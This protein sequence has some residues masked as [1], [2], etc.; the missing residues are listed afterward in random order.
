M[1]RFDYLGAVPNVRIGN[2]QGRCIRVRSSYSFVPFAGLELDPTE[3][4]AQLAASGEYAGV[5]VGVDGEKHFIKAL[6]PEMADWLGSLREPCRIDE[7]EGFT[8]SEGLRGLVGLVLDG[9]LEIESEDGFCSES[10]AYHVLIADDAEVAGST[11]A[12]DDISLRAIRHAS[13]FDT[14]EA[15]FLAA[16]LY[17]YGRRPVTRRWLN[18]WP[19]AEAV[20]QEL[21]LGHRA[22][23]K[24]KASASF[25]PDRWNP[26]WPWLSWRSR[27][28]TAIEEGRSQVY[29][30]YLAPDAIDF[31]DAFHIVSNR[32]SDSAALSFKIGPDAYGLQRPDKF[33]V[34][35]AD[36]REMARFGLE[37]A[38]A[39]RGLRAQAVPFTAAIGDQGLIWWG[40][41]SAN[42]QA[43]A[44][45]GFVDSWRFWVA[46]RIAL[47]LSVANR[48]ERPVVEPLRFALTRL[49]LFGVD[50]RHWCMAADV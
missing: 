21:G 8:G 6:S 39:L 4:L 38:G 34:Y 12:G 37:L 16:R 26:E 31:I 22:E 5:L 15:N 18:R 36:L 50:T 42:S 40:I 19:D 7:V 46:N 13:R 47:A 24:G 2:L 45:L 1:N 41:D 28:R 27:E 25:S 11:C 35:F 14:T 33:I 29:K 10:A 30:L 48:Q 3:H 9:V 44:A 32:L 17:L 23:L 20:I 43:P 49:A